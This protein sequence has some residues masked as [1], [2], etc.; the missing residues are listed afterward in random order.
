MLFIAE[1]NHAQNDLD[2]SLGIVVMGQ[3]VKGILKQSK[4]LFLIIFKE[5]Y[6]EQKF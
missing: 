6:L 2:I 1:A 4:D 5:A 3:F